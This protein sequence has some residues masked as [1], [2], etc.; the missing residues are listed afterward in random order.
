MLTTEELLRPRYKVIAPWPGMLDEPFYFDQIVILQHHKQEDAEW[1]IYI[2][3]KS[4]PASFMY[5]S[6]FDKFPHLFQP[7]PWWSDREIGDMPEY[8][9]VNPSAGR[10]QRVIKVDGENIYWE[11]RGTEPI[12]IRNKS[13]GGTLVDYL[14]PATRAEYEKYLQQ[15]G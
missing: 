8:V 10:F 13:G 11:Y 5:Q 6:F 14:Q 3:N 15:K 12:R 4:I 9:S 2:P 1:F 7:L